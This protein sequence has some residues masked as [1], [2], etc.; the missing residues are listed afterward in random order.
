M[1]EILRR[2]GEGDDTARLA[3]D[4][5]MHRL[6][7]L[8]AAMAAAM[9]GIDVLVFTGGVGEHA[10]EVR[11]LA[12]DGLGFLGV[13]L[14]ADRNADVAPDAEIGAPAAPVRTFVLT[15]REDLEM[16]RQA[17]PLLQTAGR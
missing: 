17:R 13:E 8:I 6:R 9:A 14:D 16:A 1:R 15:A 11:S 4:V 5:Y 3:L 2:A 7:S 12:V 10:A